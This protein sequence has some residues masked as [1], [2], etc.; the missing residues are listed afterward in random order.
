MSPPTL[1]LTLDLMQVNC[2]L[3]HWEEIPHVVVNEN[4]TAQ[5]FSTVPVNVTKNKNKILRKTHT[6]A[7]THT[8]CTVNMYGLDLTMFRATVFSFSNGEAA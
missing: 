4:N 1:Q 7:Y 8:Q 5:Q 6:H 2:M 3:I